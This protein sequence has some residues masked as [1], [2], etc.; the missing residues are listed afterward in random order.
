MPKILEKVERRLGERLFLKGERCSGPKCAYARRA[1]PPGAHGKK[2][3][4]GRG[5]RGEL[6]D[7]GRLLKEKKK[8]QYWYGVDDRVIKRYSREAASRPGIFSARFLERLERRLDNVLFR[9][10]FVLS[11]GTARQTINHGHITV[12]GVTVNI[13]SFQVR[14]GNVVA[15]KERAARGGRFADLEMRLKKYEP[16]QWMRTDSSKKTV[17]I[18]ALP[19]FDTTE[20]IAE[21]AKIKELYSR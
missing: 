15:I 6:S 11:R 3:G 10:G 13:P 9:A 21:I 7:Y 12:D 1:Y 16:P 14:K 4:K 5:R 18:V 17:V 19:D 2:R 20:K 8:T